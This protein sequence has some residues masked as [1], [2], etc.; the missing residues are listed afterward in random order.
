MKYTT[1]AAAAVLAASVPALGQWSDDFNRP[2]GP[3][4]ANWNS[5]GGTFVV[6]SNQGRSTGFG[7]Q[8]IQYAAANAPYTAHAMSVD[9]ICEGAGLQYVALLSGLGGGNN[10]Y[11]KVQSQNALGTFDTFG[12][13]QGTNG[14]GWGGVGTGFFQL[15]APFA[16]ARMTVTISNGG[17]HLQLDF[18][19]DF[20]GTPD[21]TY[22]ADGVNQISSAF[23]TGWG[24]GA[25]NA[26]VFDNWN[27][28]PAVAGCY[29][30]CD[31]D[32]LLTLADFGC[33]QTKFG[34]GDPYADCDGDTLLTLA[35]FGCF[36]TAFGLGC[37]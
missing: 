36:Q 27:V 34:L 9:A 23:G 15:T 31:G 8:G 22:L 19:T 25:F 37:P 33:F 12:I 10:L 14:G 13:Y 21:Q 35:D 32:T 29:P 18:D 1:V 20:N 2:D 3:I 5:L 11:I 7:I 17:D 4:G 24:I 6:Q 26:S 28:G 30:D 16:A